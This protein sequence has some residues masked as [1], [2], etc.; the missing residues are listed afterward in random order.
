M[1]TERMKKNYKPF[2]P[3]K[4]QASEEED[5]DKEQHIPIR[6]VRTDD[7]PRSGVRKFSVKRIAEIYQDDGKLPDMSKIVRKDPHRKRTVFTLIIVALVVLLGAS[8]GGFY[9]FN[10]SRNTFSGNNINVTVKGP[11]LATSGDDMTLTVTI[12]NGE[13]ISLTHGELTVLYPTNFQFGSAQ[14][15]PLAD[16]Q[17]IWEV[18]DVGAGKDIQIVLRGS[19]VGEVG[20]KKLFS[21]TFAYVPQNFNSEFQESV[22]FTVTL[23]SSIISLKLDAPLRVGVGKDSE[24]KIT[25][26]NE[27]DKDIDRVRIQATY[28]DGFSVISSAPQAKEGTNV[29]DI[30]KLKSGESGTIS[31]HGTLAGNGGENKEFKVQAGLLAQDNT[32]RLQVEKSALILLL[33]PELSLTLT[34]GGSE[35]GGIAALGD[36][37]SYSLAYTNN[38]DV[39]VKNVEITVTLA[40][41]IVDWDHIIDPQKGKMDATTITWTSDQI[42]ALASVKPNEGSTITFSVPVMSALTAKTLAKNLSLI[43]SA[44][45]K[46]QKVTDLEGQAFETESNTTVTKIA[47]TFTFKAE[48]RYYNDEFLQVGYGPLPPTVGQKTTYRIFWNLANTS[49]EVTDV[50]VKTTLPDNVIWTGTTSVSAGEKLVYD[51]AART[52]TWK[53]NRIPVGV[54]I[55]LPE[56]E[57]Y[58]DLTVTPTSADVGKILVL[59]EKSEAT[60]VDSYT[61]Q[62]LDITKEL[63][64]TDLSSDP[65]AKG[66]GIVAEAKTP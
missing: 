13:K 54:G 35:K 56:L 33:K 8:L 53:I 30:D 44:K 37:I 20:D 38:G 22:N 42:A 27:S 52:V 14:P 46:S 10:Q 28:P 9:L 31:I 32:F 61:E 34:A 57:A 58:F 59:S 24:F 49:N 36:L 23:G 64:T 63:L 40:S 18:G 41:P 16:R 62:K 19:L 12:H 55:T 51:D 66:K 15:S 7:V 6:D 25:Y 39:E 3:P 4:R 26:R 47:S 1:R 45:A 21:L 65:N 43:A 60:G 50:V 29:W 11:Q 2:T 17:N 48:A 5:A